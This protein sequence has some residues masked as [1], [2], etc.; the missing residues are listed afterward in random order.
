MLVPFHIFFN[1]SVRDMK[2][3]GNFQLKWMGIK[4]ASRELVPSKKEPSE[5]KDGG[6]KETEEKEE[7]KGFNL[8]ESK[9]FLQL[10]WKALPHLKPILTGFIHSLNLENLIL[11]MELGFESSVDT[12]FLTGFLWAVAAILKPLPNLQMEVIPVFDGKSVSGDI[13]AH[14]NLRLFR[15]SYEILRALSHKSVRS[16]LIYILRRRSSK[17]S[18][19]RNGNGIFKG[20]KKNSGN[21]TT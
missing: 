17:N 9:Q 18:E 20:F 15:I 16:M 11:R 14:I 10:A 6:K 4:I 13:S 12:E 2:L 1:L 7:S 3:G 21:R 8:D 19:G 5:I